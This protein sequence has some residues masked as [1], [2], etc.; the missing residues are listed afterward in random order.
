MVITK[1]SLAVLVYFTAI[2]LMLLSTSQ[3]NSIMLADTNQVDEGL[4]GY[5]K[6]EGDCRDYS[7][8]DNHGVNHGV[9]LQSSAFNGTGSYIEVPDHS[10]LDFGRG[11]FTLSTWIYTANDMTDVIGDILSKYDAEQRKGFTFHIQSM[12]GAGSPYG[13][14]Q[15]AYFGIDNARISEWEDCGRPGPTSNFC[16]SL[17]VYN[18]KLYAG[19]NDGATE[20]DW[21]RV[22]SYEGGQSWND[23][24]QVGSSDATGVSTLLV[25]NGSLYAGTYCQNPMSFGSTRIWPDNQDYAHVYRYEGDQQWRDC[26]QPGKNWMIGSL[27]SYKGKL[28]VTGDDKSEGYF[29]CSSY[30]GGTDWKI[31]GKFRG[32]PGCMSVHDG[33]LITGGLHYAEVHAYDGNLWRGLGNPSG[34]VR[35]GYTQKSTQVY[36]LEVHRGELYSGCWRSGAVFKY[37][38]PAWWKGAEWEDCGRLGDSNEVND[39]T[40]YNG[41]LYAG[42]LPWAEVY[43]YEGET[44]WALVTRFL[45]PDYGWKPISGV[46]YPE[47]VEGDER[48][49]VM[50]LTVYQGRLFAAVTSCT[51][52]HSSTPLDVR[53][54]IYSMEAGKCI[55]YDYD[56]GPGWKYITAVKQGGL[57]KLYVNGYLEVVSSAF[58]DDDYD[59]SNEAP[60]QIGYGEADYFTGNMKEVRLYNR[61]LSEQEIVTLYEYS[62]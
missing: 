36:V 44:A 51:G 45:A 5:W 60:L 17:T 26:G 6:L 43:R 50:S 57:L 20:D 32:F 4:V 35:F 41:K 12:S 49:R 10:S 58:D 27:V 2:V 40:M 28:Y 14:S 9:D 38:G 8:L 22:Y 54:K 18:G 61:A 34:S 15:H 33:E 42:S 62:R 48:A 11:D 52:D 3:F 23:C 55:S 31:R 39:L 19:I 16:S 30:E 59:I 21:R 25:H 29:K 56:L 37:S 1:F 46:G 53:G 7:G 13:N 47:Q 24:G